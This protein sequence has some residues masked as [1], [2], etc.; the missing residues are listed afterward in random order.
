[1]ENVFSCAY[2]MIFVLFVFETL[3][4]IVTL[5]FIALEIHFKPIFFVLCSV[6]PHTLD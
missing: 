2:L 1:M 3:K 4:N 5:L 6:I